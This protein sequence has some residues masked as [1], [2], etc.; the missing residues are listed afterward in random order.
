MKQYVGPAST[1]SV[2]P[3]L[4]Q[5]LFASELRL[6]M[7]LWYGFIFAAEQAK[8][9]SG[10]ISVSSSEAS[11]ASA[12]W[13]WWPEGALLWPLRLTSSIITWVGIM[14]QP[15]VPGV[16]SSSEAP[17]HLR[18]PICFFPS[19]AEIIVGA[20]VLIHLLKK[21]LQGLWGLPGKILS[22]RS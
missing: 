9:S 19:L 15:D 11:A 20:D 12:S 10:L 4:R 2:M 3:Q 6:D 21:L 5:S 8:Q 17:G 14:D 13:G 7:F 16:N 1:D 18:E 22:H